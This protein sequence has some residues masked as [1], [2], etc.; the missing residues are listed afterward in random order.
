MLSEICS[1]RPW[2]I[3]F[4]LLG[5]ASEPH[6]APSR[7]PAIAA[8][9]SQSS[10]IRTAVSKAFEKL[11]PSGRLI[12]V[13][14]PKPGAGVELMNAVSMFDGTGKSVRATQGG[15]TNPDED[16]P[17]YIGLAMK[18]ILDFETLHTDTFTLDEVNDGFDLLRT[19]N[20]GRIMI[21]IGD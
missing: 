20:A 4:Q 2:I 6:R 19:G 8:T 11:A 12:L 17:R 13:G 16:I 1:R 15:R 21:K 5:M 10:P 14:Q 9:V 3:D 18:G 7:L